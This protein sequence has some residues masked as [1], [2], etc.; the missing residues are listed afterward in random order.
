MT[1]LRVNEHGESGLSAMGVILLV[2]LI[3]ILAA[4]GILFYKHVHK[5]ANIV[6][7]NVPTSVLN[8]SPTPAQT[9]TTPPATT[10]DQSTESATGSTLVKI[11][12]LGIQLTVPNT[13]KDLIYVPGT[14][15]TKP[16]A[17]TAIFSTTTLA[18]LDPACGI[19]STKTTAPIQG[20]GELFEYPGTFT[21]STNPDKTSVYGKQFPSFYIAYNT[22]ASNCSTV[23]TTTTKADSQLAAL[24]SALATIAPIQ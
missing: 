20:I 18:N 2:V 23:A 19:D 22:P 5:S 11:T 14:T 10:T 21:A 7:S 24:K 15:K 9:Q 6:T 8:S 16:V 17:T 1:G 12:Q 13:I 4:L 3:I